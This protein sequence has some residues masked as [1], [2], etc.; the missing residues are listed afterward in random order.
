MRALPE[1]MARRPNLKVFIVGGHDVSYGRRPTEGSYHQRYLTEV[2]DR[3]DP[4][5]IFFLGKVSYEAFLYLMQI[6]RCHVYLTY[7]FVLSWSMLEAMSAG[8]VVVGS[9]TPPVL[10]IIEEGR[11]GLLVDFFDVSGLA[12]RVCEVLA[13]PEQFQTIRM[14]ARQSIIERFDL[15]KVCLPAYQQLLERVVSKN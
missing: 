9:S 1:I 4:K 5:R 12:E 2:S 3:L 7:P 8:A 10:D 15:N 6:T 13:N 11:T 14:Q